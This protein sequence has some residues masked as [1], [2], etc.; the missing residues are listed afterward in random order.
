[1][2]PVPAGPRHPPRRRQ[3]GITLFGLMFYAIIFG[4]A[5]YLLVRTLPTIN[6]YL[7][8]QRTVNKIAA[9]QPATV[10]EVRQ[11]FDRQKEIEYSISS[12]SGR[13]LD[14]TKINDRVV[15]SFAYDREVPLVGPV[16]LL[17]KYRGS[18]R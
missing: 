18:S 11:A 3:R 12:I 13:D 9:A 5:G 4:F 8:I 14:V 7:T 2:K 17:L 16:Y 15:V 1:M 6:E 10:A